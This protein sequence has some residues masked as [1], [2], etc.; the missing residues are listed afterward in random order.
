VW[1]LALSPDGKHLYAASQFDDSLTVFARDASTGTLTWVE[2]RNE[3]E[4]ELSGMKGAVT[5]LIS[6]DG[7]H[8]YLAASSEGAIAVFARDPATGKLTFVEEVKD[9]VG[10]VRG[11]G[12]VFSLA[13]TE[14]GRKLYAAAFD[15]GAIVHFTRDP[16][17]G[18]L[19]FVDAL[20]RSNDDAPL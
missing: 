16:A 3:D 20:M 2:T 12:G 17:T 18:K 19:T 4:D 13:L 9:R 1:G 7:R 6:G 8:V 11:I 14:D 5:V 15:D 10:G